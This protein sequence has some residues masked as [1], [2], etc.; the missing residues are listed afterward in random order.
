EDIKT[1]SKGLNDFTDVLL[2]R[3][4]FEEENEESD[5]LLSRE[6]FE[7]MDDSTQEEEIK[8]EKS[9]KKQTQ[10]SHISDSTKKRNVILLD[11]TLLLIC[12]MTFY[13][14]ISMT[15]K[16]YLTGDTKIKLDYGTPYNEEGATATYLRKDY[17]KNIKISGKVN[18]DKIGTYTI[19]YTLKN[20]SFHLEKERVIE[21]VDRKAPVLELTG[22]EETK[23]CPNQDYKEE[24]VKAT[25][26][27]DGD[28]TE[29]IKIKKEKNKI[30][31]TVKDS[32][33][34]E[35]KKI[36]KLK[37][38][39]D[40]APVLTLEGSETMYADFQG[41]YKEPGYKATDNCEGDLT[42]KVEV[43]GTVDTSKLGTYTLTYQVSDQGGNTSEVKRKVIVSRRTDPE[44]GTLKTGAI[45][46]T[47]DDGPNQGTTNRILDI[48]K[49]EGVKATFFVTC[50]GPDSLIKREFDEGHSIALHTATHDYA[51]VYRS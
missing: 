48:L 46:L 9:F 35:T 23:V 7:K 39:D 11:V 6:I 30:T 51:Y 50:N 42:E 1:S 36:R 32:S 22:S 8:P 47:F 20:T 31:Y 41:A 14:L 38:V 5:L 24:G 33:G 16:M 27:Y 18:T 43:K 45:Y 15:P 34:N 49:E 13:L 21:V 25:D 29:Q 19:T 44:S 3:T 37:Q 12:M 40:E 4:I 17:T 28:L 10:D 2:S 26:E